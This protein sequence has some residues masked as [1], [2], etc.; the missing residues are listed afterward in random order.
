MLVQK[1]NGP[2]SYSLLTGSLCVKIQTFE[3]NSG[4]TH[5]VFQKKIEISNI[6][7]NAPQNKRSSTKEK[8]MQ[9]LKSASSTAN[10]KKKVLLYHP[11]KRVTS[12]QSRTEVVLVQS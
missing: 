10:Q 11:I 6:C 1:V 3:G 5:K 12:T 2:I 4:C 9:K 8:Q 7:R